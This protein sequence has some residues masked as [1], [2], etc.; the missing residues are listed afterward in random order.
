MTAIL[1]LASTRV[2]DLGE[3]LEAGE[4]LPT[5]EGVVVGS[6]PVESATIFIFLDPQCAGSRLELQ[7]LDD[8][9][10]AAVISGWS[11]RVVATR[12]DHL[13][14]TWLS[15]FVLD[16]EWILHDPFGQAA[17]SFRVTAFPSTIMSDS[18][19]RVVASYDGIVRSAV[20]RDVEKKS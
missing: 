14:L 6:V 18:Q 11:V 3:F 16:A 2:T 9:M 5:L 10:A 4:T 20:L 19:N 17:Q 1:A 12:F 13:Q 15:T 7:Y 8:L